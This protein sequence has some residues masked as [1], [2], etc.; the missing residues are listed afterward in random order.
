MLHAPHNED[1]PLR[2]TKRLVNR[3]YRMLDE[4]YQ[5]GLSAAGVVAELKAAM[6]ELERRNEAQRPRR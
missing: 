5:R 3:L 1:R 4:H 2:G 6:R